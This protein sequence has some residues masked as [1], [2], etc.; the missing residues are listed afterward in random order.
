MKVLVGADFHGVEMAFEEFAGRA[1]EEKADLLVICGDI[2]HFGTL[3]QAR[4]LLSTLAFLRLP[5]LFVPGNC[6]P[7]SLAGVD[8]EGAQCIHGKSVS[9]GD[10]TFTGLGGSSYTPFSTPF[11]LSEEEITETLQQAWTEPRNGWTVLVSHEPPRDTR[12][13]RTFAGRHVGSPSVRKFIEERKPSIVFCGH[14]H[15]ARGKDHIND[16]IIV[17]PGAA[18]H[19]NYAEVLFSDDIEIRFSQP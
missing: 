10:L 8:V 17:N 3:Q 6:D 11:E 5:L 2:T 7:P 14:I 1:E 4:H 12:V 9:V 16:T 13:D 19:G 15:E 18:R